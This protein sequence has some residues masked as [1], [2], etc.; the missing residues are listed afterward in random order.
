MDFPKVVLLEW[1][2]SEAAGGWQRIDN[3]ADDVKCCGIITIGF[4]VKENSD[5]VAV[6]TSISTNGGAVDILYIPKVAIVER[7]DIDY[8]RIKKD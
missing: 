4:L 6:T 5:T 2:D 1:M 8:E 3:I 7:L